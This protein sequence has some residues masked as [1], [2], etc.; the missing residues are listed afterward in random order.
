MTGSGGLTFD[1][2]SKRFPG[3]QALDRVSFSVRAG[4]VHGLLG[5]NGAGKS[6]LLK[7]LGGAYRPDEGRLCLD[8]RPQAFASAGDAFQGGIAVIYQ[9]PQLIGEVSVAENILLGHLPSRFGWV[10]RRQL[11]DRAASQLVALGEDIDPRTKVKTLSMAQRQMVEIAKALSRQARVIAFDEP[12][13]SLSQREVGR[14]FEI[15]GQLRR[16]GCIIP[17]VSHRLEE[18]FQIADSAT[19]LRDGRHVVTLDSL[20]GVGTDVL[21]RHMVGRSIADIYNYHERPLGE[22]ALRVTDLTGPGLAEPAGLRVAGGEIVGI[23]GLV[24]A[25]RTELL[26]LIYGAT[27]PHGGRVEVGG[28]PVPTGRP[29]SSIA[30]GLAL[31]PEDRKKEGIIAPGSVAENINLSARRH[32]ARLGFVLDA[33]R[34]RDNA[35]ARVDALG[36]RTPSLQQRIVNLSGGN[37]QKVILARWL[38]ERVRVLLLDEPTRGIDVGAK[39]EIYSIIYQLAEQGVGVLLV[40]SELPEILGICD[41]ILV[42]RQGRIVASVPRGQASGERLPANN[43][44]QLMAGL[45]ELALPESQGVGA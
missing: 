24:G 32:W 6:T 43:P 42:M 20:A 4:S 28:R 29:A 31:C 14:L 38:S 45:L 39:S 11:L 3:V 34:E 2:I 30:A 33:A 13:S 36:I 23:F 22:A 9:E 1:G 7:V 15:I 10:S 41:R 16:G 12:T 40:S 35:R 26:K 5:E 21:V 19:V 17:Y 27:R 25:G 37:Q 8:G 18:I 44:D